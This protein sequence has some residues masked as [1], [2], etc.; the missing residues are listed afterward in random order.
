M[1]T[2]FDVLLFTARKSH[3]IYSE[4]C[5]K[6][7]TPESWGRK[8]RTSDKWSILC[9]GISF[10]YSMLWSAGLTIC[11]CTTRRIYF[12]WTYEWGFLI[13]YEFIFDSNRSMFINYI[14][15]LIAIQD[16]KVVSFWHIIQDN[17]TNILIRKDDFP[18]ALYTK[19]I[20]SSADSHCQ[21]HLFDLNETSC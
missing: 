15:S 14:I 7:Q 8:T 2:I 19:S 3:E 4:C 9:E 1:A 10:F 12:F 18:L 6:Q 17:I 5:W 20:D 13:C 16:V 21:P 11:T